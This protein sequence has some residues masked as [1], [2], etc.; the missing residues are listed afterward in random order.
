MTPRQCVIAAL[1]HRQPDRVPI[2]LGGNQSGIHVLA[3][4]RVMAQLGIHEEKTVLS[5]F[6]Q[7]LA[8]PCDALLERFHVDTRWIRPLSSYID[9]D[10][11]EPQHERGFVGRFDQFHVFWGQDEIKPA[12]EILYYD[13]VIH[14][15]ADA[16]TVQ[17]IERHDWPDG[18]DKSVFKGL[19]E[20]ARRF[21]EETPY[22]VCSTAIGNTF[23]TCTFL[24]GLVKAMRLVRTNPALLD[25]AMTKLL[26]YWQ[27]YN[28]TYLG[29]VGA[30][31]DVACINGDLAGQDGPLVNPAF[32]EKHVKP[33][34][35]LL[36]KHI[37]SIAPRI[38]LNYHTCGSVPAFIPHLADVG[39]DSINP[40]Q[41]SA[42]DME[43]GSLKRRFGGRIA[44]WGGLCNPQAT[45]P[46]GTPEQVRAE[47]KRN[48]HAFKAGGGFIAANV[49][50]ITAEVP[51]AN[52]VAMFDA[53]FES[54]RY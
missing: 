2:D 49:H 54:G 34:D 32:Y 42:R 52:I 53:A 36:V 4:Q 33:V 6:T 12:D 24:F 10:R 51:A 14:P 3:Y 46:F 1:E 47:V 37:K 23:E 30:F 29:E 43:P 38:K 19:K 31:I 27:D 15:L 8:R 7:Q 20:V 18:K 35:A 5:H 44:F 26:E 50:N 25:A 21:H 48:V 41:V 28:T 45:L 17:D 16:K 39:F 11:Q 13:P 9:Y 22:A 40:V